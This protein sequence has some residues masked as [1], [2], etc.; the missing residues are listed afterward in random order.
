MKGE[1]EKPCRA[2]PL[3]VAGTE[4]HMATSRKD[5]IK[6]TVIPLRAKGAGFSTAP[7]GMNSWA[8]FNVSFG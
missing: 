1:G 5:E 2:P 8:F 6:A 4:A 3:W 7:W